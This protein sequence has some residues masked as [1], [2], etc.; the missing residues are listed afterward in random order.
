MVSEILLA[1]VASTTASNSAT[2][3]GL[4]IR[5]LTRTSIMIFCIHTVYWS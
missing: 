3:N 1:A 4:D 5:D 2:Q